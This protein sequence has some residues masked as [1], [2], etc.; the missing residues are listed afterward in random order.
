MSQIG[1]V[2]VTLRRICWVQWE[3]LHL[4]THRWTVVLQWWLLSSSYQIKPTLLTSSVCQHLMKL[5]HLRQDPS[6]SESLTRDSPW[7]PQLNN[8]LCLEIIRLQFSEA[9][10]SFFEIPYVCP[11]ISIAL[12][13]ARGRGIGHMFILEVKNREMLKGSSLL[14]SVWGF[15]KESLGL[16]WI[17]ACVPKSVVLW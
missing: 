13:G 3:S 4:L 11:G 6:L 2:S 1:K 17:M 9:R 15:K 7:K 16:I 10:L 8:S 12:K 14:F 5:L